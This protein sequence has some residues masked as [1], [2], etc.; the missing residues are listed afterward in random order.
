MAFRFKVSI[1]KKL[2]LTEFLYAQD[3]PYGISKELRV[4][5]YLEKKGE[6]QK[7]KEVLVSL[8]KSNIPFRDRS[9]TLYWLARIEAKE[10]NNGAARGRLE[11]FTV[12]LLSQ[13]HDTTGYKKLVGNIY[14]DLIKNDIYLQKL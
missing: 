5:S 4:A 13:E 9:I 12:H 10:G 7:A 6:N 1:L 11:K 3:K 14:K 8:L 2:Y